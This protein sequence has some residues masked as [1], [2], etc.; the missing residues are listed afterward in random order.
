MVDIVQAKDNYTTP[1]AKQRRPQY[2]HIFGL[3]LLNDCEPG[4]FHPVALD[5]ILSYGRYQIAHKLGFGGFGVVWL[6]RDHQA[7]R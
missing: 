7:S 5:D 3:E 6:G 1:Q 2:F 4:R